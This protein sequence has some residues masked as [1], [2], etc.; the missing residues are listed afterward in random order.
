MSIIEIFGTLFDASFD[1]TDLS[2]YD[3]YCY[4]IKKPL[5]PRQSQSTFNWVGKPGSILLTKKFTENQLTLKGY[6]EATDYDDLIDK[7]DALSAA[8]YSDTDVQLILSKKNDRYWLVQYMDYVIIDERDNYALVDLEFS[9]NIP[10]AFDT[11]ADTEP[12]DSPSINPITVNG[13]TFIATNGGH[14]YAWPV[15]TITFNQAQTHIYYQNNNI[16]GNRFD[17]TRT[18]ASGDVLEI[19]SWNGTVK[20][21][22]SADYTGFGSGGNS[23]AEWVM[24]ATGANELQVGTDDDSIDIDVE[25]AFSKIYFS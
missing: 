3:F 13:T 23:K 9:C 24:L 22:G 2:T 8:L 5:M 25:T 21:N 4:D 7:L 16:P 20:L 18:F 6:I 17:V 15:V 1:G 12:D 10:L 14:Y 11:T 19:D